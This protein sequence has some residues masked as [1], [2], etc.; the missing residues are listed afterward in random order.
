MIPDGSSLE[1]LRE[2]GAYISRLPDP[3][4]RSEPWRAATHLLIEAA[5]GTASLELARFAIVFA[6]I[7]K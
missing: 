2:A 5:E 6:L 4:Y 1:T 7:P 3:V